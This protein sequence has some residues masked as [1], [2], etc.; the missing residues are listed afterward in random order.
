VDNRTEQL[1]DGVW[2]VEVL[3]YVNT[4]VL[5]NDGAGDAEGLTVVDTGTRSGGPRLV[6]SVRMLG[7]DPRAIGDV[8]LTH[9]H[10]DHTGS[11][12]RFASSSASPR[13][14]C[15]RGDLDAV[16][17]E[18][19]PPPDTT[20]LGRLFHRVA[21]RCPPAPTAQ[22]LADGDRHEA[23]GGVEVIETPGHT[24]G[25]LSFLL[26]ARGV[27]IAGDALMNVGFLSR[28]PKFSASALSA[29][30]ATLRRIADLEWDL[31][32]FGHGPPAPAARARGRIAR[33]AER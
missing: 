16:R 33:L 2:R 24:P 26:P 27:L 19:H 12:A 32:A 11:A 17:G 21:T 29:Q 13:V 10:P 31:I 8:L 1:A 18:P 4:Y 14:W 6:R 3:T 28:G 25:H 9:R 20:R 5:A 30:A 15:G 7:F 22:A 23:A